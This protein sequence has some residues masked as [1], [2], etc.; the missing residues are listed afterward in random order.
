ARPSA[1][2]RATACASTFTTADSRPHT[3]HFHRIHLPST[4]GVTVLA[5][6]GES[7][8]Y[9]LDARLHLYYCHSAE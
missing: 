6:P 4:D 1:S 2:S 3:I 8:V 7:L 9:E 5:E